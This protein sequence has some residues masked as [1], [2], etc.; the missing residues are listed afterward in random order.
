[1]QHVKVSVILGFDELTQF[2]LNLSAQIL[3]HWPFNTIFFQQS[4]SFF[5]SQLNDWV[6]TLK[7]LKLKLLVDGFELSLISFSELF[8]H[9]W[10]K[11]SEEV[12]EFE[13]ML[14]YGHFDIQTDEL[15]HV[16]VSE[17]VLS[18]EDWT[19]FEDF[20]EISHDAHLLV[21]LWGLGKAGF[22]TKVSKV[23][24]ISSSF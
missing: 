9:E 12:Q 2:S 23:E 10:E 5:K 4:N 7:W 24:D 3:V 11:F 16:P 14:L 19:D 21:Q 17:G 15:T 18:S 8:E 6:F 1:M 13:I 22:S 20:L